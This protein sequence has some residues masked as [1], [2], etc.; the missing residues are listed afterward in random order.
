M[1]IEVRLFAGLREGRFKR[2]VL[3]MQ[4]KASFREVLYK[5]NIPE[6]EVS[7]PL[8]N[9]QYSALDRTLQEGDVLAIFPAVGGG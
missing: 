5:L 9:G 1:K 3:P 8:V 2:S 6:Q 7:L 4:E